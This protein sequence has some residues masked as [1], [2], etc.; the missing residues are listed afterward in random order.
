MPFYDKGG[1]NKEE[2]SRVSA[3]ILFLFAL[4][5]ILNGRITLEVCLIGAVLTAA[6]YAFCVYALGY[7]LQGEKL[8]WKRAG[9]YF[10]YVWM[11]V[12]EVVKAN[13]VVMHTIWRKNGEYHPAM[14]RIRVPFRE[15][16]SRVILSNSITLTPGTVTV[17]QKDDEF[18]VLCLNKPS[19]YDI[20]HWCLT[21]Y[22]Q[23]TE[24][25]T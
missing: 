12:W 9:R 10:L 21:R 4:W 7:S 16:I 5:L 19:A 25:L 23:K 8:F 1:N 24:E 15:N 18:L 13:H 11:L 20:P 3:M 17:E 6:I 14:V 22:L 2:R